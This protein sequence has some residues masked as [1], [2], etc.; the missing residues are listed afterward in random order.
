MIGLRR[1]GLSEP[2]FAIAWIVDFPF[3]EWDED[4]K[5]VEFERGIR[6]AQKSKADCKKQKD[7]LTKDLEKV[8]KSL[9]F[10]P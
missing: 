10:E 1:S 7:K 8:D 3:F 5:K 4:N 6:E 2:Y 9:E